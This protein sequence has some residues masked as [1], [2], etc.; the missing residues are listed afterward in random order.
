VPFENSHTYES[1]GHCELTFAENEIALPSCPE[2]VPSGAIVGLM[3]FASN[4]PIGV[5]KPGPVRSKFG[6]VTI[7]VPTPP[8]TILKSS[9]KPNGSRASTSLNF[10]CSVPVAEGV[11]WYGSSPYWTAS[12][13]L[14]VHGTDSVSLRSSSVFRRQLC[15]MAR[16][17]M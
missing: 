4:E 12:P 10:T 6:F 2:N 17:R 7:A 8:S 5:L 3:L 9:V 1:I 13:A 16:S 15:D 11:Q 14:A